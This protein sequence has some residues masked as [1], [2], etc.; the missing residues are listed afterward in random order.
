MTV[1]ERLIVAAIIIAIMLI[2]VLIYQLIA[3]FRERK[4]AGSKRALKPLSSG[5]VVSFFVETYPRRKE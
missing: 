2:P 3:E 4:G 1:F 5:Q